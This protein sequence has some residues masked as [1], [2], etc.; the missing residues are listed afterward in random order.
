ML[1]SLPS[2]FLYLLDVCICRE[3]IN[4]R[5]LHQ[6]TPRLTKAFD[7]FEIHATNQYFRP[8]APAIIQKKEGDGWINGGPTFVLILGA[9]VSSPEPFSENSFFVSLF[10]AAAFC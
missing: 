10:F 3:E 4:I 9:I 8:H 1:P 7:Q 5:S 2:F 6:H